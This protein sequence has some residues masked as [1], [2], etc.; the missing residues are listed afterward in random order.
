MRENYHHA[1]ARRRTG[2]RVVPLLAL[3]LA[4]AFLAWVIIQAVT[5]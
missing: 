5:P 2:G 3:G 1:P 4:L